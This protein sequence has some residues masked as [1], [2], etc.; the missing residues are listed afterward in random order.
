MRLRDWLD[1]GDLQRQ[2]AT[3]E[4][5]A[6]LF[7]IADRDLADAAV[8]GV[9]RDG[10]FA[11]VYEAA[12]T[13]A[14][15][16]LRAAGYRTRGSSPGHHWLTLALLPEIMGPAQEPRSRYYQACRRKRHQAAYERAGVASE[17][18]IEEL[19]QDV[20]AFRQELGAWLRANAAA[21]VD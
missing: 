15:I 7:E 10:Q 2:P 18:E 6:R 19:A 21:L 14:M 9:S 13:L 4:E 16:A 3:P 11:I 12:L 1:S 5:I 20:T 8:K 17:V